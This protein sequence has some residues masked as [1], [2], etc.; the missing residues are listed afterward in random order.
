VCGLS[1]I[2]AAGDLLMIRRREFIAV[3]GGAA[4]WPLAVGAQRSSVPVIGYLGNYGPGSVGADDER[5]RAAVLEGLAEVGYVEGRNVAIEYR[6]VAGQNE[7]LPAIL[8]DLIDERRVA[9]LALTG[10]TAMALAAKAATQTIPIVFRIGGDPVAAGLVPSLSMPGG[11]ITGTTTLGVELGPKRLQMLS[12]LL[13]AGATVALF[14]NPRNANA[15]AETREIQAATNVLGVR[16]LVLNATNP[17]ELDDVFER[18][19]QHDIHGVLN[20]ADPFIISQRDRIVALAARRAIPAIY[21]TLSF[22]EAGGLIFYGAGRGLEEYRVVGRY[23]GRILNGEKPANLPVQRSTKVE[24][25]VNLKVAK[26]L[27]I[28]VPAALLVRADEVIE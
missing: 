24:L 15:A 13:P 27:G 18:I 14:T 28:T 2:N 5:L 26:A 8:H 16:L 20:A 11:N 22:L 19:A 7:K 3:V 1:P 12:E 6:W 21:S 25:A 4:V 9:V 17:S 10:S 23:V